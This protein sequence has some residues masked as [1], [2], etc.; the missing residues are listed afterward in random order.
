MYIALFPS[1]QQQ[2]ESFNELMKNY[3][4]SFA[5]AFGLDE[6]T[7]DTLENFLSMEQFSIIW[8]IMVI[9]MLIAIAGNSLAGEIER[10]T[11]ELLLSRPVSRIK[12]FFSKYFVG[13]FSLFAFSITS[14]FAVFP[15]AKIHNIDF[16]APNYVSL[17]LI[18][19]LFGWAV[20]S[21]AIFF[22][23]IFSERS[24][25]YMSAGGILI[26]MYVLN[27]ISSLKENFDGLKYGSFFHYYS[28]NDALIHN[29]L[30]LTS[31][32]IFVL[33]SI[34]LTGLALYFFNKRDIA[35]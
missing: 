2:S 31:I 9:F 26:A 29:T 8:P 7:F 19:F 4:E 16:V 22:S 14:I 17:A 23:A 28:S 25:V 6:I 10:G 33:S 24:K 35:I 30:N 27:L 13:I 12:I 32:L 15:L 5:K 34:L 18:S 11:V 20:F 3:P 21:L 1:I